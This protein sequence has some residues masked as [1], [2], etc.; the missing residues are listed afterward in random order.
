MGL[1]V[2]PKKI[3]AKGV[4]VTQDITTTVVDQ[5]TIQIWT[6]E[7]LYSVSSATLVKETKLHWDTY[8][9]AASRESQ[10]GIVNRQ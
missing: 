5:P 2:A 9:C 8:V 7:G 4:N 6:I 1:E 10:N 3:V